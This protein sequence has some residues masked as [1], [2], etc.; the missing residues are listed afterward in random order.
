MHLGDSLHHAKLLNQ[1]LNP[2][3]QAKHTEQDST[4]Q[5][6][7]ELWANS[8]LRAQKVHD[9]GRQTTELKVANAHPVRSP[10]R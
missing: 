3:N 1:K 8:F 4:E 5:E 9:I 6:T 7:S 2:P 10:E